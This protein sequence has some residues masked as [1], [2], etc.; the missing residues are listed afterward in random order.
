VK[1]IA[2][3]PISTARAQEPSI[4]PTDVSQDHSLCTWL[5]HGNDTSYP[6]R[7]DIVASTLS[8]HGAAAPRWGVAAGP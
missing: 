5:S 7:L 8:V 4:S 1:A 2:G 6:R 3:S